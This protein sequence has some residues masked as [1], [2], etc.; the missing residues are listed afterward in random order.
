MIRQ[1]NSDQLTF[2]AILS[3]AKDQHPPLSLYLSKPIAISKIDSQV[4]DERLPLCLK[5]E[6]IK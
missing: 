6:L 5:T 1:S 2:D 4:P 3:A